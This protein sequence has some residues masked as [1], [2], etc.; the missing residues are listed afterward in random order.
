MHEPSVSR[1]TPSRRRRLFCAGGGLPLLWV[2]GSASIAG[3]ASCSPGPG[4]AATYTA[5]VS[6]YLYD[7]A[8]N[9]VNMTGI[10]SYQQG[11]VYDAYGN[12]VGS[13]P[14][15]AAGTIY[16]LQ[17]NVIGYIQAPPA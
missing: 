5:A 11:H 7:S 17:G 15:E 14:D 4:Y 2:L 13:V 1:R 9:P 3:V 6:I 10:D 8:G 12:L 16:N